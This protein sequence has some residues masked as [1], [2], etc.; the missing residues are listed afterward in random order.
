MPASRNALIRYKTIDNCLRNRGRKW[1][2]ENLMEA[3][4]DALAE[5]EGN[6]NGISRRTI[7]LDLQNMRSEKMGYNAPIV[8]YDHKYYTYE[9]PDYSIT[10]APVNEQ[11]M[12]Q[13]TE[14]VNIIKQLS[15]FSQFGE[16]ES[17]INRLDAHVSA[18]CHKSTPVI[19]FDKNDSL[20]GLDYLTPIHQAI[21]D[22]KVLNIKYK[23]FKALLP[24]FISFNPYILKEYNNRWFVVGKKT[25]KNQLLNLALDRIEQMDTDRTTTYEEN[26]IADLTTYYDNVIGVTKGVNTQPANVTFWASRKHTPY[27]LTKPLH[28]S[29][30]LVERHADG[31]ADFHIK[32][33]LN[34]ELERVLLGFGDGIVVKT[35]RILVKRLKEHIENAYRNY[36]AEEEK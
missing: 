20:K 1:T 5:Y 30:T 35:P 27:I 28:A 17:I 2:L 14:A 4:A 16:L 9:D 11:D 19:F 22:K 32:V 12:K 7:Q 8:V 15:G 31:S 23:S 10:N 21:L 33:C 13:V 6:Y 25:G 24:E 26:K 29:Q 18:I 3:C 36:T 34:W